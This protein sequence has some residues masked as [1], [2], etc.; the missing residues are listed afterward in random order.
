MEINPAGAGAGVQPG[1][2]AD[3]LAKMGSDTFMQ[4]LVAQLKYQNPLQ[5]QNQMDFVNQLALFS[6]IEQLQ[7]IRQE[8]QAL[9]GA[10]EK[11]GSGDDGGTPQGG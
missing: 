11:G 1:A 3:K 6:M 2:V 8:I 7:A 4:L 10:L 9:P 5:P